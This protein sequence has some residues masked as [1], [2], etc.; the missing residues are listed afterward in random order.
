M[1]PKGE[2]P[3]LKKQVHAI[4]DTR[5]TLVCLEVAGQIQPVDEPFVTL[6]GR[7]DHPPFHISCRDWTT[8]WLPGFLEHVRELA[9]AEMARRT[10]RNPKS[11]VRSKQPPPVDENRP[12]DT[13]GRLIRRRGGPAEQTASKPQGVTDPVEFI[14]EMLRVRDASPWQLRALETLLDADVDH[15]D[16]PAA[17][18]RV[19]LTPLKKDLPKWLAS[20][21]RRT[22]AAR[23]KPVKPKV[24]Q[25]SKDQARIK[26]STEGREVL[27]EMYDGLI[28]DSGGDYSDD[29]KFAIADYA[30]DGAKDMNGWLRRG[31]RIPP[32]VVDELLTP[33]ETALAKTTLARTTVVV[34]GAGPE[35]VDALQVGAV[36][37]DDGFV[38]TTVSPPQGSEFQ[39]AKGASRMLLIEV[40]AGTHVLFPEP[41]EMEIML[42][43]NLTFKVVAVDNAYVRMVIL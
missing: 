2:R 3:V 30:G 6:N 27:A 28:A 25:L 16:L 34:R 9:A 42:P 1:P 24:P 31:E 38:S 33:L 11:L 20:L 21:L 32:D 19:L 14:N 36:F 13:R 10:P 8:P 23:S 39:M 18:N 5:T 17:I 4:I 15:D 41:Y 26:L 37:H 40:P 7:F 22:A 43:R 35:V 29:E 12:V